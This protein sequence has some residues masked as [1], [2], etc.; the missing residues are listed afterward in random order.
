VRVAKPVYRFHADKIVNSVDPVRVI[1]TGRIYE[2][3]R[4]YEWIDKGGSDPFDP[5]SKL[6]RLDVIDAPV[7]RKHA[8]KIAAI[9]GASAVPSPLSPSESA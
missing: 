7:A 4:L 1:R 3:A 6:S 5:P 9:L 8:A 2:R